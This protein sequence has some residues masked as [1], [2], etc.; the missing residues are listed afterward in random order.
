MWKD[1][2]LCSSAPLR[3]IFLRSAAAVTLSC[4]FATIAF[5]QDPIVEKVLT[6]MNNPRGVAVRPDGTPEKCEVF[7]A[8]T[9]HRRVIKLASDQPARPT[10]VITD[11]PSETNEAETPSSENPRCILFLD[12]ERLVVGLAGTPTELRLYEID[13][14]VGPISA[15]QSK[16]QVSPTLPDD[17]DSSTF[18]PPIAMSRTR[19]NDSVSDVLLVA[20]G[21]IWKIPI[22]AGTLGAMTLFDETEGD[23]GSFVSPSALAVSEQGYA[24]ASDESARRRGAVVKFVNPASRQIVMGISAG[25]TEVTGLAYSSKSGNLYTVGQSIETGDRGVFRIDEVVNAGKTGSRAIK[26]ASIEK[27]TALAFGP[28]GALYITASNEADQGMLL[29]IRGEL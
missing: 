21:R 24:V 8:E 16:Q 20:A 15:E 22:R 9:G 1:C 10:D 7:V 26:I 12:R 28:D 18:G 11:F 2:L 13:D 6:G 17:E 27:P 3:D 29:R 14:A 5:A 19:P 23:E 25:L 4:Y